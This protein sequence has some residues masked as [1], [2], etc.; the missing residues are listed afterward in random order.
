MCLYIR[1]K[2]P[3]TPPRK[4]PTHTHTHTP[5][6]EVY[7]YPKKPKTLSK[8]A[9]K[10]CTHPHKRC[11]HTPKSPTQTQ[12]SPIHP[13]QSVIHQKKKK[14]CTHPQKR[15]MHTPK[16]PTQTHRAVYRHTHRHTVCLYMRPIEP[17]TPSKEPC[18][19]TYT[20]LTY[21]PRHT[22][23]PMPH[24]H[25]VGERGPHSKALET[26]QRVAPFANEHKRAL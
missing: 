8:G 20:P 1:P 22:Y 3:R 23:T 26:L 9:Q 10:S 13:Q 21:T 5:S 25:R 19:H 24:T 18:R 15:C 2:E 14:S 6:K 7:T 4:S 16:S 11:I 12:Q 17:C